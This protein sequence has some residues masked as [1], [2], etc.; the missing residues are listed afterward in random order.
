MRCCR[1]DWPGLYLF[2]CSQPFCL[3][4]FHKFSSLSPSLPV[5]NRGLFPPLSPVIVQLSLPFS[6][7]RLWQLV[8]RLIPTSDSQDNL[9][10]FSRWNTC[11]MLMMRGQ[12]EGLIRWGGRGVE[13]FFVCIL[14]LCE[15][16]R[17]S[18]GMRCCRSDCP[19]LC[20][21]CCYQPSCVA[22]QQ[23]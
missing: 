12:G 11:R 8:K 16:V 20:L 15:C 2:C 1:S 14:G 3:F 10:S 5:T 18:D 21:F 6:S 17:W 19:G 7:R 9:S 4:C 22:S 23:S 13:H